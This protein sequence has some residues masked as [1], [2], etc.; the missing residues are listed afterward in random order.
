MGTVYIYT[1]AVCKKRYYVKKEEGMKK[2]NQDGMDGG[3][4]NK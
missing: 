2:K 4:E 1:N 3:K